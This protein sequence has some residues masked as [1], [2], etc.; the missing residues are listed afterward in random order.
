MNLEQLKVAAVGSSSAREVARMERE[1][2]AWQDAQ[3]QGM[4]SAQQLKAIALG[5]GL[6]PQTAVELA[7]I[8]ST[9]SS[10]ASIGQ[11]YKELLSGISSA[12]QAFSAW[13][14]AQKEQQEHM[15]KLL[16]PLAGIRNYFNGNDTLKD[17]FK[18]IGLG[19]SEVNDQIKRSLMGFSDVGSA[20]KLWAQ[21]SQS[22]TG[23]FA[24]GGG[25]GKQLEEMLLT[26]KHLGISPQ[27]TGFGDSLKALQSQFG[28][29]ALPAIDWGSAAAL[30]KVLGPE[31]FEAQLSRLGIKPDGTLQEIAETPEKGLLS[32]K[33]SDAIALVGL[34]LSV[35]S[36]W[37]AIQMFYSQQ[38]DGELQQAKNDEQAARQIRQLESLTRLVEKALK[39]VDKAEQERFF[40][41]ARTA[42]IRAKPVHGSTVEGKLLPNEVVRIINKDRKWVEVE[43]Y[44]WLHEEYRTGWVLK[45]YLERVPGHYVKEAP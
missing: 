5:G 19:Y 2:A 7:K 25:I 36:I 29:I 6:S 44:H 23:S 4:N 41:R 34:L 17:S 22:V 37:M 45:K 3:I 32:R 35:L 20:A 31:G 27:L 38:H 13:Q 24:L 16:D 21:Q 43:Y 26:T 9:M 15:R 14:V 28:K 39:Q 42:T 8:G 1:R 33:Q 10:I 40:V 18:S 11:N 30:A 12:T